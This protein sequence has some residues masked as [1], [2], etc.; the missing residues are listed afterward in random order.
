MRGGEQA[1][2]QA[3][4]QRQFSQVN[5]LHS[6]CCQVGSDAIGGRKAQR[7]REAV[8]KVAEAEVRGE[9]EV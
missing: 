1:T 9:G 6:K 8:G 7:V 4:E 2:P 3:P 5:M